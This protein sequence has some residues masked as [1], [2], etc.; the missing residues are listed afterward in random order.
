MKRVEY[1]NTSEAKSIKTAFGAA[2]RDMPVP[3]SWVLANPEPAPEYEGLKIKGSLSLWEM[4]DDRI[5]KP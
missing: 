3:F 5:I 2:K 4:T 1:I